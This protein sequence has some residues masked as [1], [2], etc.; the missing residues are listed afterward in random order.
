MS[1]LDNLVPTPARGVIRIG[2]TCT[3]CTRPE[4]I[5]G[6]VGKGRPVEAFGE[7]YFCGCEPL[8]LMRWDGCT[9][10]VLPLSA[11]IATRCPDCDQLRPY[12]EIA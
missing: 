9:H 7:G 4:A 5:L 10:E 2:D 11:P 1:L 8:P 3:R 6:A 12:G